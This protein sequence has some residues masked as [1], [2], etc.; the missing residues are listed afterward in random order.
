MRTYRL[1]AAVYRL[2]VFGAQVACETAT[3]VLALLRAVEKTVATRPRKRK[4]RPLDK[5]KSRR[6]RAVAA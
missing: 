5:T 2:N 6:K 3:D 1:E 4:V